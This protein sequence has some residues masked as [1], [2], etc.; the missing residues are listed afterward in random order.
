LSARA[1]AAIAA[2][3]LALMALHVAPYPF[4]TVILDTA[5]D[6][7]AAQRL[8]DAGEWPL[9]GPVINAM[10]YLGPAWFY[11]VAAL[12][13]LARSVAG[14]LLLVGVLA[15]LKF[16]LAYVLGARWRGPRYGLLFALALALPGWNLAQQVLVTHWNLVEAA[17]IAAALPLLALA[18]GGTP[19]H[20]LAYGLLQS[21]A[22]HA[23]PATIVLAL[24][25]PFVAR[26]RRSFWRTDLG[27]VAGGIALALLPFV[28]M[29]VAEAR[30]G[31]PALAAIAQYAQQPPA[32]L[33]WGAYLDGATRGGFEL[34][35]DALASRGLV[36]WLHALYALLALAIGAGLVR[37]AR[38][39][40]ARRV[41][42]ATLALFAL[43]VAVRMLRPL[44]PFYMLLAWLP[45]LAAW[46]ALALDALARGGRGG[47]WLAAGACAALALLAL[48]A[49][50][51]L[52]RRASQGTLPLPLA[53]LGD[54][55][56]PRQPARVALLP[57]R[58][59]DLVGKALC[60]EPGTVLHGHLAVLVDSALSLG[61]RLRCGDA[62]DPGIGGGARIAGPHRLGLVPQA[63]RAAGVAGAGWDEARTLAPKRVL[64]AA[65]TQSVPDGSRYPFRERGAGTP[66]VFAIE[67]AIDATERVVVAN[68]FT[69]YDGARI[70]GA[71]ADGRPAT[72]LH[73]TND[74]AVFACDGCSGKVDWLVEVETGFPDRLDIV[75]FVP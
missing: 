3:L 50:A 75:T 71:R 9:R 16:P 46:I 8:L 52:L 60:A 70:V 4:S 69:V 54:V 10:A 13:A 67:F 58:Q 56:Q 21:L 22:L 65:G 51:S 12:L 28:P 23:H 19:R 41:A 24:A 40:E 32:G 20:W 38:A 63:L 64:A 72:T 5:R 74:V 44:T 30:D 48:A 39:G 45:A 33:G 17:V 7:V 57:A 37:A 27:S 61:S 14:T 68:A 47:R 34:F 26:R 73:A 55:A 59:L 43:L 36:P 11:L 15:S 62:G 2:A 1:S 66:S 42:L 25:L 18:R 29:L 35:T 53:A 6:L 49:P 31:W